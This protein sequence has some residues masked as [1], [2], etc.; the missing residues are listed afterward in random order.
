MDLNPDIYRVE[1]L[2]SEKE[3]GQ[4]F[5]SSSEYAGRLQCFADQAEEHAASICG[6]MATVYTAKAPASDDADW[7]E[8]MLKLNP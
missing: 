1:L 4:M 2:P 8:G 5:M 3:M 7:F 6:V